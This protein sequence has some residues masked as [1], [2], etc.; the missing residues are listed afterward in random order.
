MASSRM[1]AGWFCLRVN[2]DGVDID[3]VAGATNRCC[4][5]QARITANQAE[6]INIDAN[7]CDMTTPSIDEESRR[8]VSVVIFRSS[9]WPANIQVGVGVSIAIT[10]VEDLI[11]IAAI[12]DLD[13][14]PIHQNARTSGFLVVDEVGKIIAMIA[15]VQTT[16][17]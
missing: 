16:I 15:D 12:A 9:E 13:D 17:R 5:A 14:N 11:P 6:G 3:P 10:P 7:A 8:D 2:F 1:C 4:D